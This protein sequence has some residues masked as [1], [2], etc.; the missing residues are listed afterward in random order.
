M[1]KRHN[2]IYET[3]DEWANRKTSVEAFYAGFLS[4]FIGFFMYGAGHLGITYF[5]DFENIIGSSVVIFSVLLFRNIIKAD[6]YHNSINSFLLPI[7]STL[8]I[9][10]VYGLITEMIKNFNWLKFGFMLLIISG[11]GYEA[12][13]SYNR[14]Y[15][16][17][18]IKKQIKNYKK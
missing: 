17:L 5:Q 1:A 12:K 9:F 6:W 11:F 18:F 2:H 8:F 15:L 14:S 7:M 16:G 3:R 4:L 13:R 10:M